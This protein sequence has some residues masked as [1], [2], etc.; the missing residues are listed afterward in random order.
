MSII[1]LMF[2]GV[3]VGGVLLL[4]WSCLKQEWP[5]T[6][7]AKIEVVVRWALLGIILGCFAYTFLLEFMEPVGQPTGGAMAIVYLVTSPWAWGFLSF[8]ALSMALVPVMAICRGTEASYGRLLYFLGLVWVV[9]LLITEIIAVQVYRLA[10]RGHHL[11]W[12]VVNLFTLS[13]PAATA[14]V[15]LIAGSCRDER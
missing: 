13:V 11:D 2:V 1:A 5:V 7:G 12:S 8:C 9:G 15:V 3:V 4:V 14:L 6:H 10:L